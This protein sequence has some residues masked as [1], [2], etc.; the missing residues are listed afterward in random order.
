MTDGQI[1][2]HISKVNARHINWETNAKAYDYA[3]D[4]WAAA[5]ECIPDNE[6]Q[7]LQTTAKRTYDILLQTGTLA[8][9]LTD[10]FRKRIIT[11]HAR[12]LATVQAINFTITDETLENVTPFY[13]FRHTNVCGHDNIKNF[14]LQRVSYLTPTDARWPHKKYGEYWE[15]E[16][17]EYLDTINEIPFTNTKEQIARLSEHYLLLEEQFFNAV[18]SIEI[19]RIHRCKLQ[20]IAAINILTNN[21]HMNLTQHI[22]PKTITKSE[23]TE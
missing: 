18:N 4:L 11:H 23:E 17:K 13:L 12:G 21:T 7:D 3:Q 19:E 14:L 8:K 9:C 20:T 22:L 5:L 10:N 15:Q 16:R 6:T 2:E 1:K